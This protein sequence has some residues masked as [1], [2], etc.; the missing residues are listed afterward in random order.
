MYQRCR[1]SKPT[2][3]TPVSLHT[4]SHRQS[5]Q[6]SPDRTR[7]KRPTTMNFPSRVE[8]NSPSKAPG[9]S[10]SVKSNNSNRENAF[11][12]LVDAAAMLEA[13]KLP[14]KIQSPFLNTKQAIITKNPNE[15]LDKVNPKEILGKVKQGTQECLVSDGS[16]KASFAEQLMNALNDEANNDILAWMPDGTSFT[17]V[18]H[19]KFAMDRMPK[20]FKIRNLSSF[21]RKLGRWGFQRVHEKKTRTSDIFRHPSFL[22]SD[23]ALV[24]QVK[25]ISRILAAE[26]AAVTP[27][28]PVKPVVSFHEHRQPSFE[29]FGPSHLKATSLKEPMFQHHQQQQQHQL[30]AITAIEMNFQRTGDHHHHNNNNNHF[31][32]NHQNTVFLNQRHGSGDTMYK[33]AITTPNNLLQNYASTGTLNSARSQVSS[34]AIESLRHD[35]PLASFHLSMDRQRRGLVMNAHHQQG[36]YRATIPQKSVS[37]DLSKNKSRSNTGQRMPVQLEQ[38]R[39]YQTMN[40][41]SIGRPS[42]LLAVAIHQPTS[43]LSGPHYLR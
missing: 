31:N 19:K 40:R 26:K 13:T 22:Q 34:T 43:Q 30:M 42:S 4:F 29:T 6:R 12:A 18:N 3:N 11:M 17:I 36:S 8:L 25:C 27:P 35:N 2:A 38:Q 16:K 28:S 32:T 41:G 14:N 7:A 23:P 24:R 5:Q 9:H 33:H 21:V 10:D 39:A 37:F 1:Y 20:L 15:V